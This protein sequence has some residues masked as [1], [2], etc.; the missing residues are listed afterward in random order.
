M[1][2]TTQSDATIRIGVSHLALERMV[3]ATPDGAGMNACVACC[4]RW[5]DGNRIGLEWTRRDGSQTVRTY[6]ALRDDAARFANLL[7]ARGVQPGDVVAGMLP[8]G[9]EMLTVIL[10]TWRAGA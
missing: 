9:A 6:D 4:D 2:D 8:R 1:D 10:G 7:T 5:A 3:L